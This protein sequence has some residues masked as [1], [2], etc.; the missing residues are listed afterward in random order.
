MEKTLI[1]ESTVELLGLFE[2]VSEEARKE[3]LSK[4]I[5]NRIMYYWTRKPLIV[6]RSIALTST[7]SDLSVVSDHLSIKNDRRAYLH[8]PDINVYK[9]QLG[10]DPKEIKVLDP[11]AGSGN[12]IFEAKRLGLDCKCSDYNPVAYLIQKSLLEYPPKYGVKLADDFEKYAK[13]VITKT[14]KEIGQFFN[15]K[16]NDLNFLWVWCIKCPHCNQRVPLT[17]QM[18]IINSPREKIGIKFH[19]TTK[20]DFSVEIIKN[21]TTEEG[22]K[23][24]QRNGKGL[25]IQCSNAIDYGTLTNELATR[26]DRELILIQTQEARHRNY[27]LPTKMDKDLFVDASKFFNS[28]LIEYEK[29][30]LVPNETIKADNIIENRLWKYGI[31][32]WNEYFSD[33]QLLTLTTLVKNSL[34]IVQEINDKDY[35]KVII[36]YLSFFICKHAMMN[37]FGTNWHTRAGKAESF[38]AFRRPAFIFNHAEINPFKKTGGSLENIISSLK[39]AIM[40]AANNKESCQIALSSVTDLPSLPEKYDL[41]ITDPPY[42]DDVQYG[43]QSEFF[44]VWLYRCLKNYYSELPKD[45]P[46]DEDFCECLGRFGNKKLAADFFEAGFAKSLESISKILKDD[47]LFVVF[48]AHSSARAWNILIKSIVKAKFK[49][50]S[51]YALFTEMASSPL[52]YQKTSFMS[53]VVLACRKVTEDKVGFIEDIIPKTEDRIKEMLN[54][55]SNE[56]LLAS[57]I[58]D[59]LIMMHGI[60]LEVTTQYTELKSYEKNFTPDY[61][62]LIDDSR[63]FIMKTLITKLTDR[64][65]NTLGSLT[66]FY[67]IAKIFYG[68]IMIAD[69]ILKLGRTY[70]INIDTLEKNNIGKKEE[71]KIRLFYLHENELDLS[72]QDIDRSNL[73]QQLCY[74]VQLSKKQGAARIKHIFTG[75]YKNFRVDD[76]KLIISL[77]IKSFHLRVNKNERISDEEKKEL[78]FLEAIADVMGIKTST[79][80]KGSMDEFL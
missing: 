41:I 24:T 31:K 10:K 13:K 38:F 78:K 55:I 21:I 11:F 22:K 50:I 7:L 58:T 63:G 80:K 66:A 35:A 52:S 75:D 70:G 59:L 76:L 40:F 43:E 36:L 46:L 39:N 34:E 69:N 37:S 73:H 27:R 17:N 19:C 61:K 25:C 23:Y 8:I 1:E 57:P 74:L 9:K 51:S 28:K 56:K 20:K 33:R 64:S 18:Y 71:D 4:I 72:Q 42:L 53:S 45:I 14:E 15:L 44:Y 48:F 32:H 16:N 49:V 29:L 2:K 47:G 3:K 68:G 12:L 79:E 54:K 26:K 6:A 30:D 60:I 65:L 62:T 77:L 67:L 5:I